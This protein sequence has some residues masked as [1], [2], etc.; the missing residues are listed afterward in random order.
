MIGLDLED[1]APTPEGT[2][3]QRGLARVRWP[4]GARSTGSPSARRAQ[5]EDSFLGKRLRAGRRGRRATT[6]STGAKAGDADALRVPATSSASGSGS[7]SPTRSTLFDPLEIVIGGGVSRAGD[8]LLEPARAS[9]RST[10][11][12]GL[13][14]HTTIR[15]ARHGAQAGVL[16]AAMIAAH[17]EEGEVAAVAT[18]R[19]LEADYLPIAEHGLIGDLHTVALVGTDGTIDW[20]CCPRFDSPSVFGA[21]LDKD[22]GGFYARRARRRRLA[23]RSSSTSRT[24]TS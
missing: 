1:G 23:R 9:P 18:A 4:P 2:F 16:G 17:E 11:V 5:D 6:W 7:G 3:P 21:I 14:R 24:P 22:K 12:P 20:Y 15:L 10:R 8:L 19:E 13:G